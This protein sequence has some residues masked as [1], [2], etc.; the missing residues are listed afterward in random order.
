MSKIFENISP[1]DREEKSEKQVCIFL[2]TI[3]RIT[4]NGTS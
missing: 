3:L 4:K 2:E 1:N